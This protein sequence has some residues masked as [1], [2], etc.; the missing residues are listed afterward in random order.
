MHRRTGGQ[1]WLD[2]LPDL[3]DAACRLWDLRPGTPFEGGCVALVLPALR[4]RTEVV[5]KL[6]PPDDETSYEAVAL[7]AWQR[8]GAVRLLE[9]DPRLRALLLE[10]V[11]PGTPLTGHPDAVRVC[12]ELLARLT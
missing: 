7:Q 8:R 4:G 5:L 11:E 12:G 9:Y 1:A 6:N 10:K 3:L 2:E